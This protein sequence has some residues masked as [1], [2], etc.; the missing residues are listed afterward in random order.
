M[1]L[2]MDLVVNHTSDEHPWFQESCDPSTPK[3]DWYHWQPTRPGHVAG[4]PGA[5][6]TNWE[7]DSP[8]PPGPTAKKGASTT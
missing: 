3:R 2:V 4:T 1:K 6:P 8:G 7:R 5:E